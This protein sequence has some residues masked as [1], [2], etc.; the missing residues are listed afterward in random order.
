M[1]YRALRA[2]RVNDEDSINGLK[3]RFLNTADEEA[4]FDALH[5]LSWV[6]RQRRTPTD[7]ISFLQPQLANDIPRRL[8]STILNHIADFHV[9]DGGHDAAVA[10]LVHNL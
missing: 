2:V 5:R 4:K 1:T 8:R 9:Q 3:E 7:A 10:F 6:Y